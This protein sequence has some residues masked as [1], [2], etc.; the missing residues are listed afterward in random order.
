MLF[1]RYGAI[2]AAFESAVSPK[3][4]LP[5]AK[6]NQRTEGLTPPVPPLN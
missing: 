2:D 3:M 4:S 1:H 5:Q 6:A